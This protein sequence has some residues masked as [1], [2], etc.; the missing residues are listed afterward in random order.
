ME[1]F[2]S[3]LATLLR[4]GWP[5]PIFISSLIVVFVVMAMKSS[6]WLVDLGN[7]LTNKLFICLVAL[8]FISIIA[9]G[10]FRNV[11]VVP[12]VNHYGF[13]AEATVISSEATNSYH[14]QRGAILRLK[15]LYRSHRNEMHEITYSSEAENIHPKRAPGMPPLTVGDKFNIKYLS[16]FPKTFIFITD[17]EE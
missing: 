14:I 17:T 5:L 9:I 11:L 7:D 12:I 3:F 16:Y 1:F 4:L 2:F 10:L 8:L 13:E 15:A 6:Q